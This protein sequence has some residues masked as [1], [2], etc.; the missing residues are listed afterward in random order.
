MAAGSGGFPSH[1]I[2]K[3]LSTYYGGRSEAHLR[4]MIRRV[5]Y[6]DFLSMYPTVCS[7]MGLWQYLIAQGVE[8][9]DTTKET[10]DL[11]AAVGLPELQR[12]DTW[13][14]FLTIVRVRPNADRF[15][16]RAKYGAP[17]VSSYTIG[18]NFLISEE[19]LWFALPDCIASKLLTGKCPEIVEAIQF[20]P[21]A[22]QENMCPIMI[23]GESDYPIDPLHDDFFKRLIE[24]RIQTKTKMRNARGAVLR[25]LDAHQEFLKTL[26]S[27]TAY[28]ISVQLNPERLAKRERMRVFGPRGRTHI[29]ETDRFEKPGPYFHPL[30]GSATTAAAR[31]M[32]AITERLII[33]SGLDWAFCDTDSMAIAKPDAMPEGEYVERVQSI[34]QWFAPL[35]PYQSGGSLLKIEDDNY[36]LKGDKPTKDLCPLF[37]Y[38]ISAK[39]Y[40]LFNLD[41]QN[42]PILRKASAHGLGHLRPPN[43]VQTSTPE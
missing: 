12:Q 32:L 33:D 8:W 6:C 41:N 43:D 3:I 13:R 26:A 31:L 27:S 1:L 4:R 11:L 34:Q 39:R 14:S 22:P 16:V 20:I 28:G 17:P 30:L 18:L 37:S 23:A 5:T 21:K 2:G 10:R 42:R 29:I 40:V 24:Y 7:L 35:N 38:V 9:R 15:P 36:R 25:A 19:P